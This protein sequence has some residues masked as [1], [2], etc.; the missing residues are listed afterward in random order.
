[1][2]MIDALQSPGDNGQPSISWEILEKKKNWT[3]LDYCETS[4][5]PSPLIGRVQN[6]KWASN[7][8]CAAR[9]G[10]VETS[11]PVPKTDNNAQSTG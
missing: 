3:Y 8:A 7:V 4:L 11:F 9:G 1:M 5:L 6:E 2:S 10:F